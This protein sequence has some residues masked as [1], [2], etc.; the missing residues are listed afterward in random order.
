MRSWKMQFYKN[1]TSAAG[2]NQSHPVEFNLGCSVDTTHSETRYGLHPCSARELEN[3]WVRRGLA[4]WTSYIMW[5][6]GGGAE[7]GEVAADV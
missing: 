4:S 2:P 1:M 5:I 7:K 6:L 3:I